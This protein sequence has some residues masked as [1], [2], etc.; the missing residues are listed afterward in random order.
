MIRKVLTATQGAYV[1]LLKALRRS[2]STYLP[3][4]QSLRDVPTSSPR[5]AIPSGYLGTVEG[6]LAP[7]G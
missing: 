5:C 1:G 2:N 3:W 6:K 4:P 7:S